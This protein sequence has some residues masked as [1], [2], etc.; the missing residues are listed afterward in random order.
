MSSRSILEVHDFFGALRGMLKP[1]LAGNSLEL[2]F[3]S[4]TDIP[5]LYTDE[6]KISQ[7]LRNLISNALKFTR[8]GH[9]RVTADLDLGGWVVF[10]VADTG[11]GISPENQ[12]RIFEEFVQIEGELQ[13][14]VKGTGLGLPLSKRLTELLGGSLT[15]ESQLGAG[16]TFVVRIPIQTGR[17][18]NIPKPLCMQKRSRMQWFYSLKTIQKPVSCIKLLLETAI[19][20]H[21]S[22]QI[23]RRRDLL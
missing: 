4:G 18:G 8:K 3:D 14:Q 19:T 11:I 13:S 21:S 23:F 20:R 15:V 17:T 7:V 22:S 9:I 5:T 16:S 12:T 6:G 10:K 1:L 2:T